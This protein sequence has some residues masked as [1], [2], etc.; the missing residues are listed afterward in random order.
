MLNSKLKEKILAEIRKK[1]TITQKELSFAVGAARATCVK[2]INELIKDGL[3]K[4]RGYQVEESTFPITGIILIKSPDNS[5]KI[6]DLESTLNQFLYL[7]NWSYMTA[8]SHD[9]IF[10][11][12]CGNNDKRLSAFYESIR[13]LQ[14]VTTET[15]FLIMKS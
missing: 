8:E 3:L 9:Y 5:K 12:K 11:L 6:L 15:H 7:G 13:I 2:F 4:E 10:L 14:G 1:P